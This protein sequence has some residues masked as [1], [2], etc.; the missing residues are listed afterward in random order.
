MKEKTPKRE[1]ERR[2]GFADRLQ[3]MLEYA[4]TQGSNLEE[5][6]DIFRER[7]GVK[8]DSRNKKTN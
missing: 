7:F 1:T 6:Q 5:R 8:S 3:R 2:I 4:I